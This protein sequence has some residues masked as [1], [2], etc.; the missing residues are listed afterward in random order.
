MNDLDGNIRHFEYDG[1]NNL[2]R[3]HDDEKEVDYTYKGLW[4][5]TSR[6]EAGSTI[7]WDY[8]TEERLRKIV[9]EFGQA[10]TLDRDPAGN[11]TRDTSFDGI[12]YRYERNSTGRV[13]R[14]HTPGG[15]DH[16]LPA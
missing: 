7:Y 6:T 1:I 10:Y 5:L 13:I 12:S 2:I 9:N 8:D 14:L 3:Y 16:Q 11:I 4:K 15:K